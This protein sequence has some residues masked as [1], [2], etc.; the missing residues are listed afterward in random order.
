MNFSR[1]N[2]TG[3]WNLL[4]LFLG[5]VS[6]FSNELPRKF[7]GRNPREISMARPKIWNHSELDL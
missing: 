1:A 3:I 7:L 6:K 5:A 2:K 4:K